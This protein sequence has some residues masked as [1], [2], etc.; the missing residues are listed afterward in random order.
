MIEVELK[1]EAITQA[2]ER[3]HRHLT[4]L[5][6]V[7]SAIGQ[8]M[9]EGTRQ[10]FLE[11]V[12]PEGEAWAPKSPVTIEAYKRRGQSV[13]FRPLFGPSPSGAG[14][15][16][17]IDMQAGRDYVEVGSNK[18]YAAVMQFGA[19]KGAFGATSRG[20]PIPW[21]DIPARPYLGISETDRE[22]ILAEIDD[23]LQRAAEGNSQRN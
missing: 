13:D 11:G 9:I 14:L 23:W 21:G 16:G 19:R 18:I 20:S 22:N 3:L 4:D 8:I 12:S 6:P 15:F 5:S 7:M 10:R 1:D 17:T 2:L